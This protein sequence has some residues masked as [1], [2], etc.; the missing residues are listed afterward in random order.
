[1]E[2]LNLDGED[3]PR[4]LGAVRATLYHPQFVTER[5][6]VLTPLMVALTGAALI[7]AAVILVAL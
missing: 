4:P 3:Y 6:D 5:I 2:D 1:M 7:L